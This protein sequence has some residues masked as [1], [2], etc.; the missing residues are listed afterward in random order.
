LFANCKL[1]EGQNLS[2]VRD[3]NDWQLMKYQNREFMKVG[4]V[5]S[6]RRGQ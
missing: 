3:W 6:Q 5:L 1:V 4:K 2:E